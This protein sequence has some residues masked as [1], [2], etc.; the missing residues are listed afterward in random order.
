MESLLIR[1][2]RQSHIQG[3]G[4]WCALVTNAI[5]GEWPIPTASK[6]TKIAERE[7]GIDG[8][9]YYFYVLRAG[10]DFGLVV[11]VLSEVEDAKWPADARGATPFDSGGLWWNKIATDP[12]LN[13]AGRRAFFACRDAP[14]TD[15]R[16]RFEKYIQTYHV[17]VSN[18]LEGNVPEP[19]NEPPDPGI[20]V[21]KGSRNDKRAWTWEVRVPHDLAAGCLDLLSVYMTE[22]DRD[23]YLDWLWHSS[24][25][26]DNESRQINQWIGN[27]V[28]V[29][30]QGVSATRA[31]EDWLTKKVAYV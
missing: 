3:G 24:P 2:L 23:D 14:L 28:I 1:G 10:E 7:L 21:V 4:D 8:K 9:P 6:K 29:P 18:Y 11:L 20:T 12:E 16:S 5:Q 31:V 13:D 17:T 19:G 30:D 26:T 15:W 22:D 25:L 27:H